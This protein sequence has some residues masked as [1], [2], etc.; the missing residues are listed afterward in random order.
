MYKR[1]VLYRHSDNAMTFHTNTGAE[2]LRIDSSG[3]L[4]VGLTS[5]IHGDEFL[6]VQGTSNS[7]LGI[8]T[9]N[10]TQ[11]GILAFHDTGGTFRG[12]VQYDH[13][14]DNLR[15]FAADG[16]RGRFLAGGGLTFNGDT[17]AANALDDYE[18]GSWTAT[19]LGGASGLTNDTTNNR[20]VKIGSMVF[21]TYEIHTLTSPNSNTLEIGGLPYQITT[22]REGTGSCMSNHIAYGTNRTMIS[23]YVYSGYTKFRWYTSGNATSWAAINGTQFTTSGAIIGSFAYHTA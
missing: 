11:S 6:S 18:E 2:R 17:A 8:K 4:L 15:F 20:Y 21:I 3:R 19:V 5:G 1:Q 13:D 14:T 9:P 22:G 7:I 10:T 12:R 23:T 16:E